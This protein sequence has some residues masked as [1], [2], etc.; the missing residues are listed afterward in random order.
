M[1]SCDELLNCVFLVKW[2]VSSGR[3]VLKLS[4]LA[5]CVEAVEVVEMCRIVELSS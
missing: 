1:S 5:N 4:K 3:I 2:I